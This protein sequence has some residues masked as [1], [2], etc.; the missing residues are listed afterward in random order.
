MNLPRFFSSNLPV[1]RWRRRGKK[2]NKSKLG[3]CA[4]CFLSLLTTP[5]QSIINP[6]SFLPVSW[7]LSSSFTSAF[8]CLF[9]FPEPCL[10]LGVEHDE[11]TWKTQKS[12]KRIVLHSTVSPTRQVSRLFLWQHG[13]KMASWVSVFPSRQ[14]DRRRSLL[15]GAS[16]VWC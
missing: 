6:W 12:E 2:S 16:L 15:S 13:K 4:A 11:R 14:H 3:C 1:S 7:L 10:Y 8:V 5:Q 9:C